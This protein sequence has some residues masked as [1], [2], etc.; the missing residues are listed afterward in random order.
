MRKAKKILAVVLALVMILCV[1]QVSTFAELGGER[2]VD[3]LPFAQMSD[4]H[5]YPEK[6]MGNKGEAWQ[7][8]SRLESKMYTESEQIIRTGLDTLVARAKETGIKYVFLSGDLTKDSE[9]EAHIGLAK[10]L[11][12]YQD[13][14]DV[15]FLVT[16]GNHDINTT[17][18]C[19][20]ENGK[21]E[22]TRA[23]TAAEFAQVYAEF[24]FNDA[25]A[26]YAYPEKGD[27]IQ[28]ALSYVAELDGD[29][30]LIV[31]DSNKYS[32]DEPAKD[33]T[34]GMVTEELMQW[35]KAQI[36][37]A[38][39]AGTVPMVMLHHGLAAHMKT[40]PSITFAFPL[41]DYM[42][43]AEQLAAWGINYVFTGHLHT[44]DASATINDDGQPLYD[45]EA[46]SL[47]GFP[48]N[49]REFVVE[50]KV[51]GETQITSEAI[52]FDD[53]A[54][55]TF[56]GVT[57]DNNSYKYKAF[58][59][60]FGGGMSKDGKAN[61]TSFLLGIVKN[62]VGSYLTQITEAGGVVPFLKTMNIDLEGILAGF[63]E[64]YIGDGFKIG[65]YNIF[66]VDN[67]MWFIN[68]LCDQISTLY[69]DNPQNLYDLLEGVIDQLAT[70]EVSEKPCTKF[71]EKFGFGDASKP[72]NL[73]DAVLSA[74]Y[75]WYTGN[76]DISDDAFIQDTLDK[77]EN[78]DTAHRIFYKLLD[79]L[80]GDIV[81]DALLSKLEIRVDKLL[82]DKGLQKK[83]GEGINYLLSY[84][85]K[86]D[87][88][89]MN[90]VNIIFALEVLPYS[91]IY[92]I[93]DQLLLQKYLTDSQLESIGIFVAYVLADF[94]T[95][96][97][98]KLHG[99]YDVT[100]SSAKCAV[101]ADQ[102]NYRMPTMVSVTMG[103]DSKT[104]AT[105]NWFSKFSL[106]D[107]DIEIYK[108]DKEPNFTGSATTDADFTIETESKMVERSYPG[109]DLGIFGLFQ[110]AFDMQQH[111]VTLSNLEPGSTY[112][113]RVGNAKYGW[114][115]Q[116]GTITTADGGNKVTFLHMTDPQSQNAK[117]YNRAWANVL[118]KAYSIYPDA[119]FIVNT[120]DLVDH[121]D[122]NKQWQY[123]FDCGAANLMNTYLMPVSGNHEGKGTNA[124]ANYFVLPNMPQQDTTT[125]VY[126]SYD[127]NNVHI[128]VLNTNNLSEDESLSTDQLE[129]LKA[130]MAKSDAQWKFVALHKAIYS[131]GSHYSDSD[132]CALRD[133]LSVLMPQLGIDMV[134]QGH[135][136]VYMRTGSLANNEK[137]DT[138]ITYLKKDG[139]VYKTQ[140]LPTGTSYVITGCSG[141]KSYIQN[142]VTKTDKY[143]PR[144]E[145]I[146]SVDAPMF[147]GIQIEDGVLYFDAYTVQG[148]E[149]TAIDRFAI[150]KNVNQGE[151]VDD[152]NGAEEEVKNNEFLSVLKTLSDY[153]L[154]IFTVIINFIEIYILNIKP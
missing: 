93:L 87:F 125:G 110:Y 112:Y 58:D 92:D 82:A 13:K 42:P 66:S 70:I 45:F 80:I 49:Y 69:I 121:G 98:P 50:T 126:Y 99:D 128:A 3:S 137:T 9:Y 116:T 108:A 79:L 134:F 55:F 146:Y 118:D 7:N 117:Q 77:L 131:Q 52:D 8:F 113:Y 84:V 141:V 31:I 81:E 20:F 97:N 109:I 37:D 26:R 56:D 11:K 73:G 74:M 68:D 95:D 38:K 27:K 143:F 136:H 100:Y 12:E 133:Q 21:K 115:S 41:D 65:S 78:G 29:Y 102:E 101:V 122:N 144:A 75:Y 119:K 120:G 86:G 15:K 10:I 114:W 48:N 76:E 23:I 103:E 44:N 105:V 140:V 1:S 18:A 62:Y 32:F 6:L 129:W 22:Q 61:V 2:V 142:D 106:E 152:Y 57:Y 51:S 59:I 153:I 149:A 63:L 83:M 54:K 14:Y 33:Q 148:D 154:K 43:V 19:T 30:R 5:Y 139:N 96:V 132:V 25:I 91:S 151:V 107:A 36:D 53:V 94:S 147:A 40:E 123:M 88:R 150:Q 46:P 127:Y 124:T 39:A 85:L 60:C 16:N 90:L 24:G 34:S 64:P 130:D 135:D 111:T 138:S 145:K 35:V 17:K 67:L 72:G 89:Y 104:Q 47:T 71:I 4:L 28:G